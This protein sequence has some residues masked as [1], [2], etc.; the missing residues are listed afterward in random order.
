MKS[1]NR[2]NALT[3]V[4]D[5]DRSGAKLRADRQTDSP[6]GKASAGLLLRACAGRAGR[7]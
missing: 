2:M 3:R 4:A 6:L 1:E 7:G 5:W